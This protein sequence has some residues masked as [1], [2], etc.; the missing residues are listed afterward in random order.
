M[1]AVFVYVFLPMSCSGSLDPVMMCSPLLALSS[2]CFV[3]LFAAP[4]VYTSYRCFW[5]S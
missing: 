3:S 1:H 4:A 5:A 2:P